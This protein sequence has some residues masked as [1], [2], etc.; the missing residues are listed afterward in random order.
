MK[1]PWRPFELFRATEFSLKV[2]KTNYLS[3][4]STARFEYSAIN[5]SYSHKNKECFT[6][7]TG[8]LAM[9]S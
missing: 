6:K 2:S 1:V 8:A 3:L 7:K 5:V 4:Q 9:F